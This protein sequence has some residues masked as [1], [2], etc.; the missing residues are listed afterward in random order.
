MAMQCSPP[1]PTKPQNQKSTLEYCKN[2][3]HKGSNGNSN[4]QVANQNAGRA[5]AAGSMK[6]P[7]RDDTISRES[8]ESNPAAYFKDLRK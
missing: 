8:F 6:A 1:I 5:H 7:G 3:R 4:G 2:G